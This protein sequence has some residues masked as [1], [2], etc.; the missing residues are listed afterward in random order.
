MPSAPSRTT[1]AAS[2]RCRNLMSGSENVPTYTAPAAPPLQVM[3]I[4]PAPAVVLPT[5]TA[6]KPQVTTAVTVYQEGTVTYT[7]PA[8]ATT[9]TT[10]APAMPAMTV[11]ATPAPAVYASTS[12]GC[13]TCACR[14]VH[15][16][17]TSSILRCAST[18][19]GIRGASAC[20]LC[21]TCRDINC[22]LRFS[23]CGA[24]C[25]QVMTLASCAWHDQST[26]VDVVDS[27]TCPYTFV[28]IVVLHR[29]SAC[30]SF[31]LKNSGG[32]ESAAS[33][34][35]DDDFCCFL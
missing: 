27:A 24:H 31:S 8:P 22:W 14:G 6:Q 33:Q 13:C 15:C 26:V 19:C 23:P 29:R 4:A 1:R 3:S 17:S 34:R 9:V 21:C 11:V 10:M 28:V 20:S 5:V 12:S 16:A 2:L 18:S 25:L 7:D 32:R 35:T 30:S